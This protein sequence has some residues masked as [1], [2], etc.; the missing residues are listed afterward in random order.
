MRE[1]KFRAWSDG[2]MYKMALDS[3]FGIS[4]FFGFIPQDAIL[5]QF[6]G[7]HDKNGK[8]IY[9]GDVL[10]VKL[11]D[12]KI[13]DDSV[14]WCSFGKWEWNNYNLSM[15]VHEAEVIGNIHEVK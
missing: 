13:Q 7:L 1:I 14:Y 11:N 6:T 12:E 8:E 10:R 9:E 5:E 3:N 2:E 4:R 15:V